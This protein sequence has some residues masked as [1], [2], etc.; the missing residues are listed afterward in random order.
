VQ[1]GYATAAI[2]VS[3]DVDPDEPQSDSGVR[4]FYRNHDP[5]PER[6]T[7][8]TIGAW[9]WAAHRALDYLQTDANIEASKIAIIGHSR[10]GKT[11]LWAG[12]QDTRFA[13]VIPNNAGD[14]GPALVRRRFGNTI[15]VMT[16]RNPHWFIPKYASYAH[17]EETMPVDQHMLIA[18]V[19]PR[20][21]HGGDGAEDLWHDP[22]GSWLALQEASKVW[23][24]YGPAPKLEMPMVN[25]LLVAG[26][27]AYHIR[28]GGHGLTLFDWKLYLDHADLLFSAEPESD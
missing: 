9:A 18:L 22:R 7:W 11:S 13:L 25:D 15:E 27:I 6:W 2:D 20:G 4:A 26:P 24:M 10:T 14:A 3:V 12:T 16:G 19:A 8:G 17:R 28:Q 5:A 23:A 21:Y 1:R